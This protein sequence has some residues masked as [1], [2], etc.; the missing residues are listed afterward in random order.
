LESTLETTNLNPEQSTAVFRI[1][2]EALTNV[3]RH[4]QA[5]RVDVAMKEE[6]AEFVLTVR[7]NGRGI[8]EEQ[9]SGPHSLGLLG[10]RER[11]HLIAAKISISGSPGE[12]TVV[13][14]RVPLPD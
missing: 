6:A 3:L 2:Q 9:S 5:N 13:M 12:G 7:D 4:A 8:T 10:M 14:V 11:S 1:F